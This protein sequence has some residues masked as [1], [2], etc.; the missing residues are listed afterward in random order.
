ML[1]RFL[2]VG[3]MKKKV[4]MVAGS[5]LLILV[6]VFCTFGALVSA[7]SFDVGMWRL[8]WIW[9]L[10]ALVLS[11]LAMLYRLKGL[12]VL[13]VPSLAMLYFWYSEIIEGAK[14]VIYSITEYYSRW[15][16]GI[17]ILFTESQGYAD[18]PTVF[19]AAAG[20][21]I[22]FLLGYAICLERSTF[23]TILC[24]AP[25]VFLTFV[26]TDMRADVI[27]LLGLITVYL[28]LLL[29]S[30][31]GPD[32]FLKRALVSVPA[33]VL[34]AAFALTV[35]LVAPPGR[36]E[37]E[38][39]MD[40]INY[41]LRV[42]LAE[43]RGLG[44]FGSGGVTW[45][46]GWPNA[47]PG[48]VWMFNTNNV[49]IAD[50]GTRFI[51]NQSL[52]EII[53]TAPGTFYL[54]GFTM[55]HFDGRSWGSIMPGS[56]LGLM[57]PDDIAREMP[58]TIAQFFNTYEDVIPLVS[59][60]IN[61]V[62]DITDVDYEP[63]YIVAE[64]GNTFQ[65][66]FSFYYFQTSVHRIAEELEG[67]GAR[68]LLNNFGE[69]TV[70]LIAEDSMQAQEIANAV[71]INAMRTVDGWED[72]S[73]AEI[74]SI[75]DITIIPDERMFDYVD[76]IRDNR[77]Y[78]GIIE[79]T[80][81]GLRQ[82]AAEAGIDATASRAEIADAVGRFV[83]ASAEYTLSP[84]AVPEDEDFV[85][86]FLKTLREGYCI[87][88][89]TAAVMMLRSLD[90]PARF[91]TG[92]VVTVPPESVGEAV[93][94]TDRNAHAWVEVFYEDVGWLYLE[95]TPSSAA[96]I[97]PPARPH[98][99]GSGI[100]GAQAPLPMMPEEEVMHF[101][102][103]LY[104]GSDQQADAGAGAGV[105]GERLLPSWLLNTI[106]IVVCLVVS[107]LTLSVRRNVLQK[108][109]TKHFGQADTN[110]AVI[111]MWRYVTQLKN[112]RNKRKNRPLAFQREIVL[113]TE[114]E[115][116]ALKARFSKHRITEE[117]RMKMKKY[118]GRL[119]GEIYRGKEGYGRLW[120]KYIRALY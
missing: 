115:D 98:A 28:T 56:T 37:R 11:I 90:I 19:F 33:F 40:V 83:R 118:A 92:Y 93:I 16:Y 64:F 31:L 5:S 30:A 54:R 14:W 96:S 77:A 94:I 26:I 58:A 79:S 24:T 111:C 49:N 109:R 55:D 73:D 52:L 18:D 75:I 81:E 105:Q 43:L 82:L 61:R 50:A 12:L 42:I 51:T 84:G 34:A 1:E 7:F 29:C 87:H 25:I 86:Y 67:R 8:F 106:I 112:K 39:Q 99:P 57:N 23:L 48:G 59:M 62:D 119:A 13:V 10:S 80:A 20:I 110:A 45:G 104:N 35:Y 103:G 91:T 47:L 63:Y 113:P 36:Y 89:A 76:F 102:E 120:L 71:V 74:V 72:L 70:Y 117:E 2:S 4:L 66:P 44:S 95:V 21:V 46:L 6:A 15:L 100:G 60:S 107:V 27:Y 68:V 114:I 17:P 3:A 88:F 41:H 22:I 53:A 32:D 69:A 78:T 38:T 65:P 85:L 97:A 9:L 116:L 101:P 108:L